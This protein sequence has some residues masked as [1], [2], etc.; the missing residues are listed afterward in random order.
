[1]CSFC[2]ISSAV[3]RLL[4]NRILHVFNSS[5]QRHRSLRIYARSIAGIYGHGAIYLCL[6][7][8]CTASPVVEALCFHRVLLSP[9]PAGRASPLHRCTCGGIKWPPPVFSS[10]VAADSIGLFS[11]AFKQLTHSLTSWPSLMRVGDSRWPLRYLSSP[12]C[13][14]LWYLL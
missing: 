3:S 11:L 12:L 2:E 14:I 4:E 1:M 5:G 9:C 7:R 8:L 13:S 6:C 10:L